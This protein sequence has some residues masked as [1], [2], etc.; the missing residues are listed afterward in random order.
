MLR[1]LKRK[2]ILFF[3]L[4]LVLVLALMPLSASAAGP[5]TT[6][7][8]L[9]EAIEAASGSTTLELGA[10]ITLNSTLAIPAGK[11][12]TLIGSYS[13][14]GADGVA[15]ITVNGTL[16]LD[17]I[18][19]TH[20]SDE[21]GRGVLVNSDGVLILQSGEI[22]GNSDTAATAHGGGVYLDTDATFT[23]NGGTISE[24]T[25]TGNSGGGVFIGA[26]ATFSMSGGTLSENTGHHGGGI[27]SSGGTITL[28]GTAAINENIA[29]KDGGGIYNDNGAVIMDGGTINTNT[30]VATGGGVRNNGEAAFTMNG[31][32]I[33]GNISDADV[34]GGVCNT[35]GV[36][37]T[38]TG[39]KITNNTSNSYSGGGIASRGSTLIMSG[40]EIS[41]N[42]A[43]E[44]GG[45]IL[46][47]E[48]NS[49]FTMSGGIISGN[50]ATNSDSKGGGVYNFGPSVF[51]MTDGA[52][53]A[54]TAGSGG[55]VYEEA[56]GTFTMSGGE[57]SGNT[58]ATSGG[59]VY[60]ADPL[61]IGGT[62]KITDN[63][64]AGT[65]TASNLYLCDGIYI[66]PGSGDIAPVDGMSVSVQTATSSGA[67]IAFGAGTDVVQYFTSDDSSK[68][69]KVVGGELVLVDAAQI[70]ITV[71]QNNNLWHNHGK[72]FYL[73][74]DSDQSQYPCIGTNSTVTV[75]VPIGTYYLYDQDGYTRT[76]IEVTDLSPLTTSVN[77]IEYDP[78][79]I[80]PI[81][82][83][84]TTPDDTTPDDQ[85]RPFV[86]V[87][88]TDWFDADVMYVYEKGLFLGTDA[89]HFSPYGITTRGMTATL[90]WRLEGSPAATTANS[91]LDVNSGSYYQQAIAWAAANNIV[92]GYSSSQFG[93]DDPV[94][95]EQF[96]AIL[97]RYAAYKQ[98]D[99]SAQADLSVFSDAGNISSYAVSAIKWA[100]AAELLQGN[101][102]NMINPSLP[103]T[104][105]EVAALLHRFCEQVAK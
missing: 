83:D 47:W 36:T 49:S 101:S 98:I 37:F 63:L 11:D 80:T 89:I 104:R 72:V 84:D 61:T 10:N 74:A 42:T 12:I 6:E 71:Y 81:A 55:G 56:S 69:A 88:A 29:T 54:N 9:T 90:L 18:T 60:T 82:F 30:A 68:A 23:M 53:T 19:V 25:A 59:G 94:T 64:L 103:T 75:S 57:I 22:S 102:N 7:V 99:V 39:G 28:S 32:E 77:Y 76:M 58:A 14:I 20:T 48:A 85:G 41:G 8:A 87:L 50:T 73:E 44:G 13:L 105:C 15:T 96:A 4:V 3:A 52:I 93:P 100:V 24:N 31:G 40:G 79:R 5:I 45:G 92:T 16:T 43:P 21:S 78:S 2:S 26:D 70:T 35:D 33:S 38:L 91:F 46:S 86:D 1:I 95:R 65:N 27:Y 62:A 97:Y 67:F 51:I 34:G 17:G 66:T